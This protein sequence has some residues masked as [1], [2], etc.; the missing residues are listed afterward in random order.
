MRR[1]FAYPSAL[2]VLLLLTILSYQLV[3]RYTSLREVEHQWH[4]LNQAEL[5]CR[6]AL[7]HFLKGRAGFTWQPGEQSFEFVEENG[8]RYKALP[9]GMFWLVDATG[10][11]DQHNIRIREIVGTTAVFEDVLHLVEAARLTSGRDATMDGSLLIA[12]GGRAPD[13][14]FFDNNRYGYAPAFNTTDLAGFLEAQFK[15]EWGT[16]LTEIFP[17][18]VQ[19][20][21]SQELNLSTLPLDSPLTVI[22]GNDLMLR[23]SYRGGPLMILAD[24]IYSEGPIELTNTWITAR[25]QIRFNAGLAALEMHLLAPYIELSSEVD[26]VSSSATGVAWDETVQINSY[27]NLRGFGA[28]DGG[29]AVIAADGPYQAALGWQKKGT[30]RLFIGPRLNTSGFV[31]CEGR[32]SIRGDHRGTISGRSWNYQDGDASFPDRFADARLGPGEPVRFPWGVSGRGGT[33]PAAAVYSW[34]AESL[35]PLFDEEQEEGAVVDE[36]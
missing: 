25:N 15:P 24:N 14:P 9:F 32:V 4:Q 26:V 13:D 21:V 7:N 34:G 18:A 10:Y 6:S 30:A 22:R 28:F 20:S 27:V 23:G 2:M 8:F 3:L 19:Q 12:Y 33:L 16:I 36:E 31:Y 35:E 29:V 11:A 5:N 17:E 1:G